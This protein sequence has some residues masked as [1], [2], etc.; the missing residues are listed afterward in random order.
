MIIYRDS[1]L[2][3]LLIKLNTCYSLNIFLQLNQMIKGKYTDDEKHMVHPK[4]LSISTKFSRDDIYLIIDTEYREKGPAH[5]HLSSINHFYDK[6]LAEIIEKV[7]TIEKTIVN[8][9]LK[10]EEDRK[11]KTIHLLVKLSNVELKKP[12]T[13]KY[14]SSQTIPLFP[15]AAIRENKTYSGALFMDIEVIVTAHYHDGTTKVRKEPPFKKYIASIPIVVGSKKCHTYNLP[16]EALIEMEEDP[17]ESGGYFAVKGI[18]W[19]VDNIESINFNQIRIF[20]NIGHQKEVLRSEIISKPGDSYENSIETIVRLLNDGQLTIELIRGELREIQFPFYLM[21]RALGWSRDETIKSSVT[22]DGDNDISKQIEEILNTAFD[23]NYGKDNRYRKNLGKGLGIYK[24]DE[25]IAYIAQN[26]SSDNWSHLDPSGNENDKHQLSN[27]LVKLFDRFL[28]PHM[29]QDPESRNRKLKFLGHILNK[30]FLVHL[31]ILE[32]TDRDNYTY[33]RVHSTGSS[34]AKGMKT[35]INTAFVMPIKKQFVKETKHTSFWDLNLS[36]MITAAIKGPELERLLTQSITSGNKATIRISNVRTI[37]NR[38]ITQQLNRKNQLS[39]LS[40]VRM[41]N[42]PHGDSA[43]KGSVRALEMRRVHMSFV[44]YGCLVQSPDSGDKVGLHKQ[45]CLGS[46]ITLAGSSIMLIDVVMADPELIKLDDIP[47][48]EI[49]YK[50]LAKVFINGKW[51]GCVQKSYEFRWKYIKLRRKNHIDSKTGI[52]WDTK[53]DELYF[54]VDFGR[55]I[56]PLLV[57]YNTHRDA[58]IL[59]LTVDKKIKTYLGEHG[60]RPMPKK[61]PKFKQGLALTKQHIN[62]LKTGKISIMNLVDLGVIDYITPSEQTNLFLCPNIDVLTENEDNE[63]YEYTHCDIPEALLGIP[64]LTGPLANHNQTPRNSFQTSQIKQACGW[65]AL[66][67]HFRIDKDTYWQYLTEFPIVKT[68]A[69]NY[70]FPNGMNITLAIMC[71]TG[72]NEEDSIIWN[73]APTQRQLFDGYILDYVKTELD[74]DEEF[75]PID[76]QYTKDL[77]AQA[78][79]YSKLDAKGVLPVNTMVEDGD[80]IISKYRK[81][82][83]SQ[84]IDEEKKYIDQSIIYRDKNPALIS[85]VVLTKNSDDIPFMKVALRKDR[86]VSIGDKFCKISTCEVLTD[87]GWIS[88]E[89]IT[90]DCKVASLRDGKHIEYIK[91]SHKYEFDHDGP[92]YSLKSQQIHT[93]CTLDHNMYVKKRNR[94]QFEFVKARDVYGKRVQFK[95]DGIIDTPDVDELTFDVDG[96]SISYDANWF[97]QLLGMFIADGCTFG[98][99][100]I[101]IAASKKR[102]IDYHEKICANLKLEYKYHNDKAKGTFFNGTYIKDENI[103]KIFKPWS[104][105]ALNKSL[106]KFVWDLNTNQSRILLNALIVGD[107]SHNKEGSV[108]YYTSSSELANDVQKLAL[109]AGWSG[110]IKLI[111]PAGTTAVFG[112]KEYQRNADTLSVRIVKTKNEP[113]INHGH[114]HEQEIQKEDIIHYTGKVYCLEVPETH[115]MYCRESQ[116]SP[117]SWTG[118][119]ARS[120]QKAIVGMKYRQSDM[121]FSMS[122]IIPDIM[123]NPHAKPSRMTIGQLEESALALLGAILGVSID[124]TIFTKLDLDTICDM[125]EKNGLNRYGYERLFSGITGKWQDTLIFQGTIYMQRLQKFVSKQVY[126]ITSGPTD[127]V[128]RQPLDGKASRGGIRIGEMEK[129][130]LLAHGCTELF[131]EKF[132]DHSDGFKTYVCRLCRKFAI[133]DKESNVYGCKQC[134]DLADIGEINTTWTSKL[135]IQQLHSMNISVLIGLTPYTFQESF[136]G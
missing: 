96:Q 97:L 30:M 3:S 114:V 55:P 111:R 39:A 9:N 113:Q 115:L 26:I 131:R 47:I 2:T 29:G 27:I 73:N 99:N 60:R 45:M 44:G 112:D 80:I 46:S 128:T 69:N 98:K 132:M 85:N 72:F 31:G 58:E 54:W 42:S 48:R 79:H 24:Q 78:H 11:I 89:D 120:G 125:L 35:H 70:I 134:N 57:V 21:F 8:R 28:L 64:A 123:L 59:G 71:Y 10:T 4:L 83:R 129:D 136:G 104:V 51:I 61:T 12:E 52:H 105:G 75:G 68:K 84:A 87:S 65:Y 66:N 1:D 15:V 119:S 82:P 13:L 34:T 18:E 133:V 67:A 53:A 63:L 109:H 56:R 103:Y 17:V 6:G 108:C 127:I 41:I 74:K 94:K 16:K 20:R 23:V 76:F 32:E 22:Y 118:N 107:G 124:A 126:A 92:M 135:F 122:G 5:H 25:V 86:E 100:T 95:K 110:T 130:V 101:V 88:F 43:S 117:P 81:L 49:Y 19:V 102:K 93:V 36:N 90:L 40:T 37:V 38:L 50:R 33:K 121:P 91:P 77:R 116:L 14:K 7:F 106:P 62:K